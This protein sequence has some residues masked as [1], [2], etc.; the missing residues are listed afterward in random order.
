MINTFL[1]RWARQTLKDH[2]GSQGAMF[3]HWRNIERARTT[4]LCGTPPR[5]QLL[6][7]GRIHNDLRMV[8]GNEKAWRDVLSSE[9]LDVM[10]EL[11]NKYGLDGRIQFLLESCGPGPV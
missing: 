3:T 6:Q 8:W 9:A 1:C 7:E 4:I 11:N 2:E 10:I 5:K